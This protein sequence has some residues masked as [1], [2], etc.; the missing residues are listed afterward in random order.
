MIPARLRPAA[1]A[2][3]SCCLLTACGSPG[4]GPGGDPNGGQGASG[5]PVTAASGDAAAARSSGATD[6]PTGSATPA[7]PTAPAKVPT[8]PPRQPM[9]A[10]SQTPEGATIFLNHYVALLN[11]SHQSANATPLGAVQG[12]ECGQCQAVERSIG[13]LAAKKQRMGSTPFSLDE[14]APP[15]DASANPYVVPA[16]L[17]QN[18]TSILDAAGA[19]VGEVKASSKRVSYVLTWTGLGWQVTDIR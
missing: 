15:A 1:L 4:G 17:I 2:L 8:S 13:D 18:A 6:G 14:V 16:R 5:A 10:Q 11:W 12:V 3:V 9:S 19:T 7:T